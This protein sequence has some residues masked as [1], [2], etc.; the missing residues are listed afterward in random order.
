MRIIT[1]MLA[2][3]AVV[4][5]GNKKIYPSFENGSGLSLN[6]RPLQ[7]LNVGSTFRVPRD[8][9]S[10]NFFSGVYTEEGKAQGD[11][12]KKPY[13]LIRS[14][15]GGAMD[16]FYANPTCVLTEIDG[17]YSLKSNE[18]ESDFWTKLKLDCTGLLPI[19]ISCHQPVEGAPTEMTLGRFAKITGKMIRF[20][21]LDLETPLVETKPNG[22]PAENPVTPQQILSQ[23]LKFELQNTS[24]L[25]FVDFG[26]HDQKGYRGFIAD[27]KFS[28]D[29]I[30]EG[31]A[32]YLRPE[33]GT[34]L[35]KAPTS[36]D[37]NGMK[38]TEVT[39]GYFKHR[40]S[41]D[42][43]L[44]DSSLR[45]RGEKEIQGVA[46]EISLVWSDDGNSHVTYEGMWKVA[47]REAI[48]NWYQLGR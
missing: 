24:A 4:A 11:F 21:N 33:K 15:G 25:E 30:S 8:A 46:T 9:N 36:V 44:R 12:G 19:E 28:K 27:N 47:G 13:C 42:D 17:N 5:L 43:V 41:A 22:F 32:V 6:D 39:M 1:L 3:A 7:A 20:A 18:S 16:E 2:F 48:R 14:G 31:L 10:P 26:E 34:K 40:F 23:Q 29:F 35:A 37:V 45:V 38:V